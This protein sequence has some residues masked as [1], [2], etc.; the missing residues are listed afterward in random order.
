MITQELLLRLF[1][2]DQLVELLLVGLV[3]GL[4]GAI[5]K[6]DA[7]LPAVLL[8]ELGYLV[9]L[10]HDVG[11]FGPVHRLRRGRLHDQDGLRR[12]LVLLQ[13]LATLEGGVLAGEDEVGGLAARRT[14]LPG[15]RQ[16]LRQILDQLL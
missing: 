4:V 12:D 11:R 1:P 9:T 10:H 5:G 6:N 7:Y 3:E 16:A 15:R 14:P 2:R 8:E 13:A